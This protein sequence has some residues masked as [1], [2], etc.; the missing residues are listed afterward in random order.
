MTIPNDIAHMWTLKYDTNISTEQKQTHRHRT[1]LWLP[2][3]KGRGR[4]KDWESRISRCKL[5]H[6]QWVNKVLRYSTGN[7]IQYP[8]MK[9]NRTE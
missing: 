8:V 9:H 6:M 3:G 2:R 4:E 5:L 7:F 1:D